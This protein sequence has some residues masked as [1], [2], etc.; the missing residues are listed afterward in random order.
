MQVPNP[1]NPLQRHGEA[2][3]H[4]Q[5]DLHDQPGR[6][7]LLPGNLAARVGGLRAAKGL[8]RTGRIGRFAKTDGDEDGGE[9][10]V[11]V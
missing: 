4:D 11:A 7:Q 6:V 3:N 9:E 2:L 1:L 8:S 10:S 5:P